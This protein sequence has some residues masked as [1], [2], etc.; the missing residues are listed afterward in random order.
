M[1][2]RVN[3]GLWQC[4]YR[5]GFDAQSDVQF[6]GHALVL[7]MLALVV[8]WYVAEGQVVMGAG[9][10]DEIAAVVGDGQRVVVVS[11]R[12][13]GGSDAQA[14]TQCVEG[15]GFQVQ[16]IDCASQGEGF[17]K[18]FERGVCVIERV[19]GDAEVDQCGDL[20]DLVAD[21]A[22]VLESGLEFL[23]GLAMLA[24]QLA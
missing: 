7:F 17:V 10:F 1:C 5:F 6:G 2:V 4:W 13:L 16:V 18:M 23:D 8:Q 11:T 15:F 9:A 24:A 12:P 3:W 22:A 19:L 14:R 21:L 20:V